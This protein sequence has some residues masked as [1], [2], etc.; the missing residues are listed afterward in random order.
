MSLATVLNQ[1]EP[2]DCKAALEKC[3]AS[4]SW[5]ERMLAGRPYPTDA[6]VLEHS[7][8][9]WRSLDRDDWLE[10]FAGHPRI[11]DVSSL[12]AKYQTTSTWA[13]NEQSGVDHAAEEVLQ[14]LAV[15]NQ[16]YEDRFGY[17]FIVCATGK[18]AAEMLAILNSRLGHEPGPELSIAAEEQLKITQLR[19][20]KLS[21]EQV[22]P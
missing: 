15:K 9:T 1:L 5:V 19:L 20:Q 6:A 4:S 8:A 21:Q 22:S 18:S 14:E 7:A 10:A 2:A 13:G 3:C 12:R 16:A 11:G 17:L